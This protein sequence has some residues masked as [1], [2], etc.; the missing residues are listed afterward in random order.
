MPKRSRNALP[1]TCGGSPLA[2]PTPRLIDGS[3]KK[4]GRSWAWMSGRWTR[5]TLP[6]GCGGQVDEGEL[7]GGA[8]GGGAPGGE[9]LLR[10][11]PAPPVRQDGRRGGGDLEEV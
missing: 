5:G 6:S 7:P 11:G 2:S 8:E 4:I 9:P 1:P 3:R 10:E